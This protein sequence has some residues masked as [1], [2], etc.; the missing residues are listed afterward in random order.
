MIFESHRMAD[1]LVSKSN[2]H[3][4]GQVMNHESHGS[5]KDSVFFNEGSLDHMIPHTSH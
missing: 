1:G 5:T 2:H 4:M 3:L